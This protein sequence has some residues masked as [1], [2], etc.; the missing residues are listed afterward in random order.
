MFVQIESGDSFCIGRESRG[1]KEKGASVTDDRVIPFRGRSGDAAPAHEAP[2][3]QAPLREPET[4]RRVT[5]GVEVPADR[6]MVLAVQTIAQLATIA[7]D[8]GVRVD[9][10]LAEGVERLAHNLRGA[11]LALPPH[12]E[13]ALDEI[14]R[15]LRPAAGNGAAVVSLRAV[16]GGS[17]GGDQSAE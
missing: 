10:G 5:M 6:R 3:A 1:A 14:S 15:A 13:D 16:Q 4:G 8:N 12:L 11:G 17:S 2:A 9:D 7:Q